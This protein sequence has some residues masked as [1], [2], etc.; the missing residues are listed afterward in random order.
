M[1]SAG[2]KVILDR[3]KE[4]WHDDPVD[5]EADEELKLEKQ[6][7]VLTAFQLQNLARF[8]TSPKPACN[9]GKILELYGDL[10]EAY[11]LSA[12]NPRQKVQYLTTEPR[13]P[14][15]LP[16]N[17]SYVTVPQPRVV[18]L[19]WPDTTFSHIRA[20]ILPSL[21]PSSDL[22]KILGECHRLLAPGGLLELRIMDAAPVRKTAGPKM[23]S[24][25]EDRLSL[26]LER[27]F[28]C[29]KPC[30]LV[31]GWVNDAG[32]ELAHSADV[33]IMRLP[34]A[35]LQQSTDVD[36]ELRARICQSMWKNIWGDFVDDDPDEAR[37]WWEDDEVMQECLERETM[38]ECGA[39]FAYKK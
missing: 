3:L 24:W 9:T 17:V 33:P 4:E 27:Q 37:W 7:W 2:P 21:V 11:Q 12:M 32:F 16:G 14:M 30:M 13:R 38:F 18:P 8:S 6:L 36:E 5:A 1:E 34:C 23:R 19:P 28:R 10:A 20:S 22:P 35:T 39:I 29:S 25:I 26:N 15:P 31:P